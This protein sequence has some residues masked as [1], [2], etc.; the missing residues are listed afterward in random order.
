[1]LL[2]SLRGRTP[3]WNQGASVPNCWREPRC[4][5]FDM[6]PR[7]AGAHPYLPSGRRHDVCIGRVPV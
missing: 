2:K 3:A 5:R 1:M 4:A 7:E 6:C